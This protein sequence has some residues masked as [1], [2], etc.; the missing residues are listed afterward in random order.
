[1]GVKNLPEIC[2]NLVKYGRSADSPVALIRW[3]ATPMQQTVTGTL[4]DIVHKVKEANL[5]P[6]AIIVVGEVVKCRDELNWFERRPLFGRMIV[7]TRAREQAS[8]FRAELEEL[9]AKCIEFPT[10]AIAPPPSWDPL[11]SAIRNLSQYDWTIFTSVNGVRFFME[12]LLAAGRDARDLKGVRLA[13]IGPKTAEAL[14]SVVLHPDLVPSE[15][16]AEAIL[17]SLCEHSVRAKRFLMP[18]ALAAREVLPE[19]LR[20]RGAL[21]DIVPAYQTV[22][23]EQ[24]AHKIRTLLTN[25]EIDCLTFTSSSTVSNFFALIGNEDLQRC[26]DRMA[27]AC[28]GPIT[29]ETAA[30]FGLKTSIM[31]SEYTI[32]GL[33]GS[34]VSYFE[35][36]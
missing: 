20:E 35:A 10:I 5:Q 22:L 3:G 36:H 18:R 28:I 14:E 12:R 17:D 21:V 6:P 7:I 27:V 4:S 34:I 24:D 29:A 26:R 19:K 32:R 30:K 15:Y 25:C 9:G 2:R 8:D 11:D 33:V 1:M 16:R 13:A 31:P 23:P